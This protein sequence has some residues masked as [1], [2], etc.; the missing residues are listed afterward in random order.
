MSSQSPFEI[1]GN[2]QTNMPHEYIGTSANAGLHLVE[3]VHIMR[4]SIP[5]I[6]VIMTLISLGAI[7]IIS[8]NDKL[9][10]EEKK[11]ITDRLKIVLYAAVAVDF[12]NLLK[13]ILDEAFQFIT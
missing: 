2:Q 10:A 4:T 1:L 8:K 12:F 9:L 7:M 13:L 5:Y 11:N 3:I 6:A